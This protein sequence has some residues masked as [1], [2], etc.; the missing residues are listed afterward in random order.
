MKSGISNYLLHRI[1][2]TMKDSRRIEGTMLSVD[3]DM[4]VVLEESEEFRC[5]KKQPEPQRRSLGL[6]VL[7]GEFIVDLQIISKPAIQSS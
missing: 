3:A 1:N 5:I 7:R 6:I 4:N 2:V